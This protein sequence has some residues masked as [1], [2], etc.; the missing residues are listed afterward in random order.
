MVS[1]CLIRL[2]ISH[3]WDKTHPHVGDCELK[4]GLPHW[5]VFTCSGEQV[6][7]VA[8]GLDL[9]SRV[10]LCDQDSWFGGT[11]N[12]GIVLVRDVYGVICF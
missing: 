9:R 7:A 11:S 10:D 8:G 12:C 6:V 4:H 5:W 3:T 2:N 1:H